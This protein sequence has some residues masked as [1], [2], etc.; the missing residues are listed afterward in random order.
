MACIDQMNYEILFRGSFKDCAKF[1][2][3]NFKDVVEKEAGEEIIEGVFLIG[4]P[5]IPVVYGDNYII[6]PYT[7]PCYGTFVIKLMLEEK[8]KEEKK[9]KKGLIEKLFRF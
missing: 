9:K 6:F 3:E 7:K 1:I 2:R 5:P 8:K 4:I